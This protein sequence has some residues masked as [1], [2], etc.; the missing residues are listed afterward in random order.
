MVHSLNSYFGLSH[1]VVYE[2]HFIS[3]AFPV[4]DPL[5]SLILSLMAVSFQQEQQ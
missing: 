3:F 4:V 2:F 1:A 5:N